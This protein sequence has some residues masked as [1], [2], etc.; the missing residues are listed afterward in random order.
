MKKGWLF[1]V[2]TEKSHGLGEA[3]Q[4]FFS[5][6]MRD[7]LT[8][9]LSDGNEPVGKKR[10]VA[11]AAF[12]SQQEM[13][14]SSAQM[15]GLALASSVV[16]VGFPKS[17]RRKDSCADGCREEENMEVGAYECSFPA[18]P[19]P[20]RWNRIPYHQLGEDGGRFEESGLSCET[21]VRE[22]GER[23]DLGM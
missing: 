9:L 16:V 18:T 21:V 10:T 6:L 12:L 19:S 3:G 22:R 11:D 8:C 7:I 23:M 1:K 14:E 2:S 17:S 20:P 4:E 5:L 13:M 15:R